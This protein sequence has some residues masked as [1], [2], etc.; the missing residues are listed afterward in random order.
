MTLYPPTSELFDNWLN[1]KTESKLELIDGKL[2]VGNSLVG[3]R[4]LLRQILQ[5][6]GAEAAIALAPIET[7]LSALAVGYELRPVQ[8]SFP[9][10]MLKIQVEKWQHT[11]ETLRELALQAEHPRTRER[12]LA[13]Y[14]IAQGQNATQVAHQSDRNPQTVMAWVHRD[15][16]HGPEALTYQRSG[17]H[18]PLCL[19]R[20]SAA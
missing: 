14:E 12:L 20:S 17:G 5:G 3:S 1:C 8:D 10:I 6:W 13:L 2:V 19:M 15:N 18:P 9:S 7:W 16:A 11:A 4:L